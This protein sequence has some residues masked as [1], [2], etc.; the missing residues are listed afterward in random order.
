MRR[1]PKRKKISAL[2]NSPYDGSRV[3]NPSPAH[4]MVS[5]DTF[6]Q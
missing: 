2:W 4:T 5:V 3:L 1:E 6:V